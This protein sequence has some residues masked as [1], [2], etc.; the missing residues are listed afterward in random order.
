MCLLSCDKRPQPSAHLLRRFRCASQTSAEL[1]GSLVRYGWMDGVLWPSLVHMGVSVDGSLSSTTDRLSSSS[2]RMGGLLVYFVLSIH[3][4][5]Q[6]VVIRAP[7][8]WRFVH[9]VCDFV[10]RGKKNGSSCLSRCYFPERA[11]FQR[12]GGAS[13]VKSTCVH[14]LLF[15]S[16]S[17]YCCMLYAQWK[18]CWIYLQWMV[19]GQAKYM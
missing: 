5:R 2:G 10:Q 14:T 3:H 19:R 12:A 15:S 6:A 9:L 13:R 4:N 18:I 16:V 7:E 1:P 8:I 11:P 17:V